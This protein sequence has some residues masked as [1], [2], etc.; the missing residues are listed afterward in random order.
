MNVGKTAFF[1]VAA[2]VLALGLAWA[3]L[4]NSGSGGRL[5]GEYPT[6]C[7]L[8]TPTYGLCMDDCAQ[9]H[10]PRYFCAPDCTC[11]L[12]QTNQTDITCS[13][14]KGGY[15]CRDDCVEQFGAAHLCTANCTCIDIG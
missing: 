13:S 2:I 5:G 1:G 11:R 14:G 15:V 7:S 8:N 9:V 4:G 10:G 6:P 12:M 3:L